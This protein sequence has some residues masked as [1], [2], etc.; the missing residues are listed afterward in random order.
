MGDTL[1]KERL[2]GD[3]LA[4]LPR[5]LQEDMARLG[6][7]AFATAFIA[8]LERRARALCAMPAPAPGAGGT[9][10]AGA[11]PPASELRLL[12]EDIAEEEAMLDGIAR[13]F[14]GS[15]SLPLQL[16]GQRFAVLLDRTPLPAMEQPLGPRA[17]CDALADAAAEL[18]L[19]ADARVA[20]Y[21]RVDVDAMDLYA[22]FADAVD[23]ALD[24][25]GILRG[26]SFV[27]LRPRGPGRG[28]AAQDPERD[29]LQAVRRASEAL[30]PEAALSASARQGR[31]DAVAA[32][33]R[34]LMQHGRDSTQWSDCLAVAESLEHAAQG[35]AAPPLEARAWLRKAF[36]QL[37]YADAEAEQLAAGLAPDADAMQHAQQAAADAPTS[38]EAAPVQELGIREQ[39]CFDRLRQLPAGATLGFSAGRGGFLHARVKAHLDD[40]PRL[41]LDSAE[42]AHE[43]LFEADLLA[44][45][46]A[47]GEAWVV[48]RPLAGNA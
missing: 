27:P 37:G 34:Y 19:D 38:A 15:A 26:M 22:D 47:S 39:R 33:A 44:R 1:V 14:S 9:A 25:A 7:E 31:R 21:R 41:L 20:L 17:F 32:L 45:M 36:R 12:D 2:I 13:R 29:A 35:Q 30:V 48:R 11:I 8:A 46:L 18:E 40:P 28:G 43:I 24:Q 5:W 42:D 6:G 23:T 16:L 4:Q 3:L 10:S